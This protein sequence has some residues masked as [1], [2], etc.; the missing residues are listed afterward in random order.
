M[1]NNNFEDTTSNS[2]S[3]PV[4]ETSADTY[5]SQTTPEQNT[6]DTYQNDS[7]QNYSQANTYSYGQNGYSSYGQANNGYSSTGGYQ[8]QNGKT[9]ASPMAIASLVMGILSLVLCCC[10]GIG[11]IVL[12]ALGIIF[13]ILSRKGKSMETMAKVGLG[14]SITGVVL[15]LITAVFFFIGMLA[16]VEAQS[17]YGFPGESSLEYYLYDYYD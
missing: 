10:I 9:P 15:G 6:A 7:S 5:N 1:E 4:P 11:G 14:L 16:N 17:D 13:A 8:P 3:S 12:G 2:G